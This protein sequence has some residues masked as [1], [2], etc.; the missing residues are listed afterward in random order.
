MI[1]FILLQLPV[2]TNKMDNRYVAYCQSKSQRWNLCDY[3]FV[4][5]R[6]L[7]CTDSQTTVI[8]K[9]TQLL[10]MYI[11]TLSVPILAIFSLRVLFCFK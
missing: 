1:L 6:I 8:K 5:N 2:I 11:P 4:T 9:I 7:C 10:Y 3:S